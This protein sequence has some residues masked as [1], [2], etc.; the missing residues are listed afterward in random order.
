MPD[1]NEVAGRLGDVSGRLGDVSGRLGDVS[2]RLGDVSGSAGVGEVEDALLL[3][4]EADRAQ[5]TE[6]RIRRLE[7]NLV[8]IVRWVNMQLLKNAATVGRE[9]GQAL[10]LRDDRLNQFDERLR[11]VEKQL[12]E[13][14]TKPPQ[15]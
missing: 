12:R 4:R 5:C 10:K 1:D 14:A 13:L 7:T 6:A 9:V 15:T 11:A 2:G 3:D 8:L